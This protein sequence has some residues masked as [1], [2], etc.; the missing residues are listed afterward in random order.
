VAAWPKK[1]K[2]AEK[3]AGMDRGL[4]VKDHKP[5]YRQMFLVPA[6]QKTTKYVVILHT[7]LVLNRMIRLQGS[8]KVQQ[9]P[10]SFMSKQFRK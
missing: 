8:P 4:D 2:D 6:V 3:P 9:F 7:V 10:M 5:W 1:G